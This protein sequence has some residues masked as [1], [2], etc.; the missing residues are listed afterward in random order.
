MSIIELSFEQILPIWRDYLWPNRTSPIESNSAMCLYGGYN[1]CNMTTKPTFF[2]C[3]IDNE[4]A[5]V[6]SGH[7]CEN[8]EYRSRGLFVFDKFRGKGIGTKLIN[9]AVDQGRLE[10][11]VVCWCYPRESSVGIHMDVGFKL[12]S[13]F[14]VGESGNNAY[15]VYHY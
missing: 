9:A 14:E 7:M 1:M 3:M 10:G 15:C 13:E 4:I 11:A 8:L 6:Y 2:A 12:E 5:G